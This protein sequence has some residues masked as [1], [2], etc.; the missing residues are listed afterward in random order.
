[1]N[2]TT[3]SVL[4][5]DD[6]EAN[7]DIMVDLLSDEFEVSVAMDGPSAIE[8]A[9]EERPDVVLLDI[10]MP[11][12]DGYE[13]CRQLKAD[14]RTRDIPIIFV[15]AMGES[16]D[17][18]KG[19]ELGALDYITKPFNPAIVRART[20][21]AVRIKRQTARLEELAQKLSKYLSPQVYDSIFHGE[22]DV[23]I[24]SRR[25]RLTVFFSDIVGFTETTEGMES[26]DL[27]RLLN[28]YLEEMSAIAIKHGGTID[29]FIGDAILIFFGDPFSRGPRADAIACVTMALEM[30]TAMDRLQKRWY[31]MGVQNPFRIRVGV[32]TGYCTVGNFGSLSRMDYTIIGSPVN[33]ASRLEGSAE[34]GQVVISHETWAL[35]NDVFD[36][37]S[38]GDP[39]HVK[40]IKKPILTYAVHAHRNVTEIDVGTIGSLATPART[41]DLNRHVSELAETVA[42]VDNGNLFVVIDNQEIKGIISAGAI[43]SYSDTTLVKDIT[44]RNALIV[45]AKTKITTVAVRA[46]NRPEYERYDDLIVVHSGTLMGT[47][48]FYRL[49]E[50]VLE[51]LND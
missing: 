49:L 12:M 11:E 34:P 27:T 5:V 46:L 42:G 35:V 43:R 21:S 16:K 47:V 24:S 32:S 36:C 40:G 23:A 25:K 8:L 51:G 44:Y 4:V 38:R 10:M 15:T 48:P 33:L 7:I 28:L 2:D 39:I 45:D 17:E 26:E 18:T 22:S 20:S 14:E 19:F 6:T 31:D 41:I 30:K 37:E 29:K 50:A 13:V 9:V 1:M 3:A